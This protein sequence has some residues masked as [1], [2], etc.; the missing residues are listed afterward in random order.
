PG[1]DIV[2]YFTVLFNFIIFFL[3]TRS[4]SISQAS[5]QWCNHGSL[6]PQLPRLKG[7]SHLSLLSSWDYRCTPP[8]PAKFLTCFKERKSHY[9]AQVDLELLA[10]S[11][12]PALASQSTGITGVSHHACN[13]YD[14]SLKAV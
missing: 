5:V 13:V 14:R 6:Q 12:S 1:Y 8:C 2:L 3:E 11:N 9:V 7:S 10:S 4:C